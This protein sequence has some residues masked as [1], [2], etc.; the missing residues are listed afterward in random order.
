MN[1][2]GSQLGINEHLKSARSY[3]PLLF[4]NAMTRKGGK[5]SSFHTE[6]VQR[7]VLQG[8][9]DGSM[10]FTLVQASPVFLLHHLQL[11]PPSTRF[12]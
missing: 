9:C 12:L 1:I 7:K 6:E 10:M 4:R 2:Q 8:W 11:M 5:F 3:M